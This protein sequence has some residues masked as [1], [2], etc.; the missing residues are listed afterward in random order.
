MRGSIRRGTL[1][2]GA[3][4]CGL[5]R[6]AAFTLIEVL[7]VISIMVLILAISIPAFSGLLYSSDQSLAEN[8]L[9]GGLQAA[10]DAAVRSAF[11]QDTAAVFFYDN[12]RSSI[13]V[14]KL[15]GKLDD[16]TPPPA[17]A[18]TREVFAPVQGF[19]PTQ[20]PFG[21]TVRGLALPG[22]IN[23]EW[24]NDSY[25]ALGAGVTNDA[26][27]VLPETSFYDKT[28][29]DDNPDSKGGV[30]H[31]FMVRFQGGTGEVVMR[32]E[33]PVIVFSAAPSSVF[34]QSGL[35]KDWD[36]LREGDPVRF[37]KRVLLAPV[38]SAAS[39]G[40]GGGITNQDRR[41]VIGDISTDTL[42]ARPIEHLVVC[43]EKRALAAV[44]IRPD[45]VTNTVYSAPS[46]TVKK[47]EFTSEVT[48]Q[49]IQDLNKWFMARLLTPSGE[50]VD[51]DARQ[52][53]VQRHMGQLQEVES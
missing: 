2:V 9:R 14:C 38:A 53:T 15:V 22:R 12:G 45:R 28:S 21:W 3:A 26:N 31:S 37:A 47:A 16:V 44:G 24:Y 4:A 52:F 42:L 17:Q 23:A 43:Q 35:F 27:W 1:G 39:E 32:D 30:R 19:D 41:K 33:A 36:A 50:L 5:A 13:V 7:L 25:G 8:A 6:R 51:S 40:E 20:L 18:V 48:T 34:R 10:R 29:S 46:V 49:K 11:G